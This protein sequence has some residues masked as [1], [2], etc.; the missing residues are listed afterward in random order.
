MPL[1]KTDPSRSFWRRFSSPFAEW[2]WTVILIAWM[3]PPSQL[4]K[5]SPLLH[6]VKSHNSQD[7]YGL[8]LSNLVR[9]HIDHITSKGSHNA[10]NQQFLHATKPVQIRHNCHLFLSFARLEKNGNFVSHPQSF[11]EALQ[12]IW[13]NMVNFK[14]QLTAG[15]FWDVSP[16]LP[17]FNG[18]YL[19]STSS[20]IFPKTARG[21]QIKVIA[22]MPISQLPGGLICRTDYSASGF[23]CVF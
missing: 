21:S 13:K 5:Q 16:I 6:I 3:A 22:G 8:G 9:H 2:T 1:W 7:I 17:W 19:H 23:Y 20:G 18:F 11:A 12:N 4:I 14:M 15:R 10:I